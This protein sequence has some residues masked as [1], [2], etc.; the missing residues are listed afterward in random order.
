MKVLFDLNVWID[1]AARP[2]SY[3]QCVELYRRLESRH[4]AVCL[5]LCGY[6][7]IY[8]ILSRLLGGQA[9]EKFLSSLGERAVR[10]LPFSQREVDLALRLR[11]GDH[12]DACVAATA[13]N[14][15]MDFIVTRNTKD[16]E[17]SPIR[18]VQPEE[19]LCL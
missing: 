18:A 7:T 2:Q 17:S 4:A 19:L 14:N 8:F 9:A 13:V 16:F 15:G 5:P 6:T 1:I 10:F 12:E 3:P 11:I